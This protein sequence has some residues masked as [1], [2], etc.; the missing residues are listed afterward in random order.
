MTEVVRL[1]RNLV[2][3]VWRRSDLQRFSARFVSKIYHVQRITSN[4]KIPIREKKKKKKK[5]KKEEEEEEG[6]FQ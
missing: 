2:S 3:C 4:I 1:T 5:K 6:A